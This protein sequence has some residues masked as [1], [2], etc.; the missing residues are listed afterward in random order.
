MVMPLVKKPSLDKDTFKNY[1]PVSSL[2]FLSN[3]EVT[4][5]AAGSPI[6]THIRQFDLDSCFQSAYKAYHS[7]E[8]ALL[9]VQNN[10]FSHHGKSGLYSSYAP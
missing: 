6:K 5:E 1:R 7:T 4:E 9:I 3:L 10:N 8:T 2:N